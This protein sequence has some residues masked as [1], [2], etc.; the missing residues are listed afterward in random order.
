M[1]ELFDE[2]RDQ[3]P[4]DRGMK[5][6][7]WEILSK[8]IDFIAQLK[9]SHQDMTREIDMLRHELE[10]IR[11]GVPPFTSGGP[12]PSIYAPGPPGVVPYPPHPPP[13]H[14]L[15]PHQP[16]Q[17]PNHQTAPPP[18]SDSRP[19]SSQN[20]FNASSAPPGGGSGGASG[21]KPE[22]AST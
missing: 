14:G 5:A 6:S 15:P 16:P 4:A 17:V 12:H 22:G 8:A 2:L 20:A 18:Q 13:G 7:K 10:S 21:P 1:K 9:Q 3:L 19:G 11:S